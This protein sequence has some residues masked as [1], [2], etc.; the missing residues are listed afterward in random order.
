LSNEHQHL[1][2]ESEWPFAD[3]TNT[4]SLTTKRVLKESYPILIV[5]HDEQGWQFLCGTTTETGD[6]K[7]VCLGCMFDQDRTLAEVAD[8][9]VGWQ[10][11][12]SHVGGTWELYPPEESGD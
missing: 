6:A 3:A 8:L 11:E 7:L 1:F 9:R 2:D 4:A 12:R 10:A 5:S